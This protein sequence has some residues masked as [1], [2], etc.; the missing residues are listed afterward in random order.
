MRVLALLQVLLTVLCL[1]NAQTFTGG[2]SGSIKD[3]SQSAVPNSHVTVTNVATNAVREVTA[4]ETG[5]FALTALGPGVYRVEVSSPSFKQHIQNIELRVQQFATLDI[6]LQVGGTTESIEVQS[7]I[8]L[9]DASTSSLSQTVENK[10]VTELPLN[11][12]NPLAFVNL[13]PG[14]RL[15]TG[16]GAN[17]ATTNW[18]SWGNYSING[19]VANGN[20]VLIDGA[21]VTMAESNFVAYIPPVDATQEFR[22]QTNNFSAEFGRSSGGVVNISIKSGTNVLHGSLFEFFRNRSLNAN[23]FFQNMAG[24][25]RPALTYNQYGGAVGGPI[26]KNKTFFFANIESFR[27]RQGVSLTTTIPTA[28]Q[29]Q[30]NFS[31]DAT[32][33]GVP[34]TIA[35]PLTTVRNA[36]GTYTRQLFPGA[37]IP[38]N[39]LNPVAIKIMN[40][41]WPIPTAPGRPFTHVNNFSVSKGVASDSDQGV[42]KIDHNLTD[43]WRLAGTYA[44]QYFTPGQFDPFNNKTTTIDLALD[45]KKIQ[46]AVVSAT[47]LFRPTLIGEFRTSFIRF[48]L[49]R[50]PPTLGYD[51]TSLGWPQSLVDQFQFKAFPTMVIAGQQGLHNSTTSVIPRYANNWSESASLTWIKGNSTIKFGGQYRVMQ[52]NDLQNNVGTPQFTFDGRFTSSNALATTATS[53]IG[54]AS[55]LLGYPTAASVQQVAMLADSRWYG[56]AYVQDDWKV[57]SKLTLNLGIQYSLDAPLTERYNRQ[58]WFDP[59][60]TLP[61]GQ[62]VGLPLKGGLQFASSSTRSPFDLFKHQIG[63]RFGYA[64]QMRRS[65]VLR[66]GYGVFWLPNN[67]QTPN[68]GTAN[69]AFSVTT[70]F[71][72][73]LDGGITPQNTLSN[74]YPTGIVPPPGSA[75]GL[76]TLL[77]NSISAY[78]RNVNNGGYVQQWNFDIQ[79]QLLQDFAV[80][81]AYAGSKG[82]HLPA[83]IGLDQLPSQYLQLGSALNTQVKNPFFGQISSGTLAQPTVAQSQLLR[84]YPQ[85]TGINL[86]AYPIGD[87]TYHSMQLKVTKRVRDSLFVVAY[88]IS[89]SV[90]NSE[91]RSSYTDAGTTGNFMDNY[92]LRLDRSLAAFDAPQRFVFQYNIEVP[93]GH[94]KRFLS[95]LHALNRLVAGWEVTGIYT[96]QAGT[97]LLLITATNS[98]GNSGGTQRPNNNGQSAALDGSARSRLNGWFNTGVFSNPAPFTIGNVARTLPDVRGN[99]TNNLDAGIFKNNYF[100]RENRVNLQFRAE[101]LNMFNRVQFGNPGSSLGTAQ[102]GVVSSQ[103]NNPRFIQLALKLRF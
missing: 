94:G 61:L 59:T 69:S 43:K 98:V 86:V 29:R 96:A 18:T 49:D 80:D 17:L 8:Q 9:L 57:T 19:G 74:P 93:F 103:A 68:T 10:Q 78:Q 22:V 89:K 12:R 46:D 4:N 65:T 31:Q 81:I 75:Q 87:S 77:G 24:N 73:S 62:Q 70:P 76:N 34:M 100:G 51:L 88:T 15:Q 54:F 97:P 40:Y 2:I 66:G 58:A 5:A 7:Q 48:G 42:T 28:L 99:G 90:G 45:N 53:G 26:R 72:S 23:D 60:A 21:P 20:E 82:T 56:M 101:F 33:A 25:K 30:G 52:L 55:Y 95:G 37:I 67:L 11:G 3:V 85:F 64:Y 27:Q 84:P 14:V 16:L 92:N 6:V 63:P 91:S 39:Q 79:Q 35:D 38:Q 71:V 13:T 36:D 102:F 32:S 50:K 47:A 83:D 41:T 44:L 1:G